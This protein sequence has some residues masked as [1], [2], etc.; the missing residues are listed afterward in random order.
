MANYVENNLGKNEK[1]VK[2]ADLNHMFWIV[3][4]VIDIIIIILGTVVVPMIIKSKTE[5]LTGGLVDGGGFKIPWMSYIPFVLHAVFKIAKFFSIELAVT[6][7]RVIGK[8]GVFSTKS[9]DAPLNKIQSVSVQQPLFGKIF[10]YGNVKIDTA[11]EVFVF[12]AIKNT[13]AFKN[14]IMAQ[15]D[16]YEEDQAKR[17]AAEMANAMASMVNK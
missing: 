6:D 7:K 16:R 8:V 10:N 15:I 17:Q 14:M 13:D 12:N 2:K 4:L 11:G 5:S 9:L 3:P 1:L